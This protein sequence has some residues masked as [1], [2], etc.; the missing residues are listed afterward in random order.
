MVFDFGDGKLETVASENLFF[1]YYE[2]HPQPVETYLILWRLTHNPKYRKWG[3]E[4]LDCITAKYK[5]ETDESNGIV[6]F[7]DV[8]DVRRRMNYKAN[9]NNL[10]RQRTHLLAETLKVRR[11]FLL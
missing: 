3:K 9:E 11:S 6:G 1:K 4:I 10:K 5:G 7:S 2:Y 8:L